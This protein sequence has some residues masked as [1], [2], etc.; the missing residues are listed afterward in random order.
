MTKNAKKRKF[1]RTVAVVMAAICMLSSFAV[2]NVNAVS[3][4]SY[5]VALKNG[6]THQLSINFG[7]ASGSSTF[8]ATGGASDIKNTLTA[9]EYTSSGTF[10]RNVSST[11]NRDYTAS[12]VCKVSRKSG[13]SNVLVNYYGLAYNY[14]STSKKYY[15]STKYFNAVSADSHIIQTKLITP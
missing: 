3:G 2:V 13:T 5:S 10:V 8:Y 9:V 4:S 6:K 12:R 14:S 11:A 7:K 15:D 1:K